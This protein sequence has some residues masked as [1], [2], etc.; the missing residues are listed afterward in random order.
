MII[1]YDGYGGGGGVWEAPT[2]PPPGHVM[3]SREFACMHYAEG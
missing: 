3:F 2:P 1:S